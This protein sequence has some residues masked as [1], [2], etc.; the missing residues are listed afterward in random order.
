MQRT[1]LA[2]QRGGIDAHLPGD[3]LLR[4]VI[5]HAAIEQFH[6]PLH[7]LMLV[8]AQVTARQRVAKADQRFASDI[9]RPAFQVQTL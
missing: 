5:R 6:Q 9:Q 3:A 8:R 4:P 2:L 7:A 1:E